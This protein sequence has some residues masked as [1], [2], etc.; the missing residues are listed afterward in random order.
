MPVLDL[1]AVLG[2]GVTARPYRGPSDHPAMAHLIDECNRADGVEEFVTADDLDV[3]YRNLTNSDPATDML[4]LE[5]DGSLAGYTRTWWWQ[6]AGGERKYGVFAHARPDLRDRL[7]PVLIDW[8]ESRA[9]AIAAGHDVRPKLLEAWA[10]QKAQASLCRLLEE[11]GYR[12]VTY[13]AMMV[14]PTLDGI[15]TAPLPP[16]LEIR[17]VEEGHLRAIFEAD[18]EAFRDHWGFAEPGEEDWRRFLEF[19]HRDERLWQVAWEGD[20]VVGQ[21]RTYINEEE[22]RA[23]GLRRGWTENISTAR[24]WRGRGVARALICASLRQLRDLGMQEA[25]LGVHTENP[26]GAFHLYESLGYEV[27]VMAT[28]YQ[29]ALPD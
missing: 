4:M 27:R 25:A 7:L 18:V 10:D 28:T 24:D 6:V 29:K 26:T 21:V 16:P 15:P 1:P 20:R 17:P 23:L 3:N 22:N 12:A 5:A 19:P 9:A 2:D 8:C 14:R 13:G 11:R